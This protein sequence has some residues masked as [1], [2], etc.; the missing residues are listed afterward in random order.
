MQII[1]SDRECLV[2]YDALLEQKHEV[3]IQMSWWGK[4]TTKYEY[5]YKEKIEFEK[6]IER[7]RHYVK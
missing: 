5:L 1:L 7:F 3:E 2:I 4:S 6:L